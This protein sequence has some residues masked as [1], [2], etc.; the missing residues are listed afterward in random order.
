MPPLSQQLRV[1]GSLALVAIALQ[2]IAPPVVLAPGPDPRASVAQQRRGKQK[3]KAKATP[4]QPFTGELGGAKRLAAERNVPLLIHLILEGESQNDEYRDNLLPH[5]ELSTLSQMTVVLLAN[6]GEHE[7]KTVTETVEGR[8]VES[9]VCSKYSMFTKCADHR[10]PWESI[11]VAYHDEKGDIGCPQ[12]ILLLPNGDEAWRKND[13]NPP[14][15]KELIQALKD[16]QKRAGP[17][18]TNAQLKEVKRLRAE[19][20]RSTDGKLLGQ[21]W[22]DWAGVRAIAAAGRYADEAAAGQKALEERMLAELEGLTARF[23]PGKAADA[24]AEI[25]A[26]AREWAES[27][28]AA[29]AAKAMKRAEKDRAIADEVRAWNLEREASEWLQSARD[30]EAASDEKA[31]KKVL[32]KLFAKKYAATESQ[33]VAREAF[34]EHAPQPGG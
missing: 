34:P 10:A 17:G 5:A 6:N 33:R 3:A 29:E 8:R 26:L 28:P 9:Q 19:A 25:Y 16:A 13:R 20:A 7:P 32:R 18:L 27:P 11:Y 15:A 4:L 2:V 30:A 24:Y 22:R 31:L 1:A 23:V 21:A 12:T 14:S